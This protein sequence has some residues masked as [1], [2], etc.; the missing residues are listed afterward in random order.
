MNNSPGS[1]SLFRL[2]LIES[3]HL[4]F[5]RALYRKAEQQGPPAALLFC[6]ECERYAQ[7]LNNIQQKIE[8]LLHI[9]SF[10]LALML[11]C[12]FNSIQAAL[13]L[14]TLFQ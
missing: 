5:L 9:S 14:T 6:I 11:I 10:A 12:L 7:A 1:V 2:S 13:Y 4:L 3:L 8:K